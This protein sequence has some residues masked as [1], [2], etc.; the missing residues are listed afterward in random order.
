MHNQKDNKQKFL[1]LKE[2]DE[3]QEIDSKSKAFQLQAD[4]LTLTTARDV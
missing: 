3:S 1:S 2:T 4:I